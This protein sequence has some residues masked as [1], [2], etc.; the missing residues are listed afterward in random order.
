MR[1]G[2]C[3]ASLIGASVV[4]LDS[5]VLGAAQ[6]P[7][8]PGLL[9]ASAAYVARYEEQ[10]SGIVFEEEYVQQLRRLSAWPH[11]PIARRM[12]SEVVVLSTGD[13]GWIGFRNVL[14]VDGKPV[15]DRTDRLEQ[16]FAVPLTDAVLGRARVLADEGAR[17]NLGGVQRNWNYPTM[18]L[19]FLRHAHQRRSTFTRDGS[20]RVDD[21]LTW[22]LRFEEVERPTLIGS[23]QKDVVASGRF[24]IEPDSG[25]VR[26]AHV[27]VREAR[28]RG[29]IEITYGSVPGLAVLVPVS[30]DERIELYGYVAARDFQYSNLLEEIRGEAR[31]SNFKQFSVEVQSK[32]QV[33]PTN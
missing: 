11:N 16:L 23:R 18:P 13:F 12:R 32:V 2:L 7:T 10:A 21:V 26:R 1:L 20:E 25:R 15:S 24:W 9:A 14:Q 19:M 29:T 6:P 5:V 3:L 4:A 17:Y 30:M 31:Y 8:V 27:V 28:S 33:G 22:R